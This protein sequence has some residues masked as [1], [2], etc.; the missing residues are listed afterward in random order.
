MII[1]KKLKKMVKR[2]LN[3]FT[4]TINPLLKPRMPNDAGKTRQL[5]AKE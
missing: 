1:R 4:I 2:S 3:T 5:Q